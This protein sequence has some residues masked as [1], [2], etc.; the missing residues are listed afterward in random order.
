MEEIEV[1]ISRINNKLQLLLKKY[2]ALQ[3]E[4]AQQQKLIEKMKA[5]AEQKDAQVQLLE[6]QQH[7]L[8]ASAGK[9]NGT[10]KKEFEQV[11]T[12]YIKEIDK[13]INFLKD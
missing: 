5:D 4:N 13:C 6:T 7:I 3:K 12:R 2:A 1:H 8:K 9:M 10:D 11:L